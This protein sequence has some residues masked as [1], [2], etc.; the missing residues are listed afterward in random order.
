MILGGFEH[1]VADDILRIMYIMSNRR[2]T[3]K[4]GFPPLRLESGPLPTEAE[5]A[6]EKLPDYR[7]RRRSTAS[8][9]P[10]T[11]SRASRLSSNMDMGEAVRPH[12]V[13]RG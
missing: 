9:L 8:G 5:Y 7:T 10:D 4:T 1:R 13:R 12:R 3:N 6:K 11:A 2:Y